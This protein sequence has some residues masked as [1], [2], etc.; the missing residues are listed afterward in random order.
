MAGASGPG[1][2]SDNSQKATTYTTTT[3]E[4][5]AKQTTSDNGGTSLA[6]DN[7]FASLTNT[8]NRNYTSNATDNRNFVSNVTTLDGGAIAAGADVALAAIGSNSYNT[9]LMTQAGVDLA[10]IFTKQ[11]SEVISHANDLSL[12][13]LAQGQA[14]LQVVTS[15]AAKPLDANNPQRAIILAGLAVVGVVAFTAMKGRL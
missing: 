1:G 6:L 8:D 3:T 13:A 15:L 12:G 11:N 14:A 5:K 4:N 7:S 10:S 9:A 2:S